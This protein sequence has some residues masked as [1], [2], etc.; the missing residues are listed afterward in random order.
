MSKD[1]VISIAQGHASSEGINLNDYVKLSAKF[2]ITERTWRVLFEMD[3][4]PRGGWFDVIVD[5][6]TGNVLEM[7]RG[8]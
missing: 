1:E 2:S 5:D 3:P 4:M 8:R 7:Q 6:E